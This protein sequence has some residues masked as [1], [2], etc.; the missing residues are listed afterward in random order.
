MEGR[1]IVRPD[2]LIRINRALRLL[3]SMEGRTI[4]RPD[5]SSSIYSAIG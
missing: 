4:V 5:K 2:D 3:P 1:T